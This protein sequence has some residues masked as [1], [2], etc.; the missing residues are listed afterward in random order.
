VEIPTD[1]FVDFLLE[2]DMKIIV[3]IIVILIILPYFN[4]RILTRVV[5]MEKLE[6]ILIVTVMTFLIIILVGCN[7][8]K[9]DD[10]ICITDSCV[11]EIGK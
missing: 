6:G 4:D 1:D 3:T 2:I 8:V 10:G 5:M 11:E 7:S 9:D